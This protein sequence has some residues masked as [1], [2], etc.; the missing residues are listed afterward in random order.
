MS[1]AIPGREHL[2]MKLL[3]ALFALVFLASVALEAGL[4][5]PRWST[6]RSISF[7]VH[8]FSTPLAAFHVLS[9]VVFMSILWARA[10]RFGFVVCATY[11]IVLA[12]SLWFRLD[13]KG[14]FGSE[15][16]YDDKMIW[17]EIW[18]K[19]HTFDFV[20][21]FFLVILL[22]WLAHIWVRN[23]LYR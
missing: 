9:V 14:A 16:F 17:Q 1:T 22:I 5:A 15:G 23:M 8:D 13:G 11:L 2:V 18:N 12:L 19:T 10:F 6:A 3:S 7:A 4:G 21:A 20:A